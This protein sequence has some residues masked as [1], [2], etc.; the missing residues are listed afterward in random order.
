MKTC[1]MT[2][3]NFKLVAATLAALLIMP[4]V[5]S[6]Q[7][8]KAGKKEKT[9]AK[10]EEPKSDEANK[11]TARKEFKK[12]VDLFKAENFSKAL[13]SFL[14]SY[15]LY[16]HPKTLLNIANCY[17]ELFDLP[18]AMEYYTRYLDEIG[19]EATDAEKTEVKSK[20][21][22]MIDK[23]GMLEVKGADGGELIIDDKNAVKLPPPGKLYL[24]AG[25]HSVVVKSE[26]K[27]IYNESI[28]IP[29]AKT[30]TIDAAAEK[31]G[32]ETEEEITPVEPISKEKKPKETGE[33]PSEAKKGVLYISSSVEESL[34][35]IN[36]KEIGTAPWEE[37]L[38]AGGYKLHVGYQGLP[39]WEKLVEVQADKTTTVDVDLKAMKKKPAFYWII[40]ASAGVACAAM[41]A[42]FGLD[43]IM[44]KKKAQDIKD[45]Y[46]LSDE[47]CGD[48]NQRTG[49]KCDEYNDL[50]DKATWEFIGADVTGPLA[51]ALA[52]ASVALFMLVKTEKNIP[53]ASIK[54]STLSPFVSPD[55][56]A[57]GLGIGGSF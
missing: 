16:P 21:D 25:T 6:A 3:W 14:A 42:G 53:D 41:W 1:R 35:T 43:G 57:G 8:G 52:G 5:A 31:P 46:D 51:L 44:N 19:G 24:S 36:G 18:K 56:S 45:E 23:V 22:R 15:T 9:S 48:V 7:K 17:Q 12:G 33:K 34:I 13:E 11:E 30:F 27:I 54:V 20:I 47:N 38:K 32:K 39:S 4:S 29:G 37:K 10:S 40:T 49:G 2:K 28:T 26:G 55:G 50:V